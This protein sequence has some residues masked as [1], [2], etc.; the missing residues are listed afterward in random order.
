MA[1]PNRR[2]VPRYIPM[3][4]VEITWTSA[5]QAKWLKRKPSPV[6]ATV[7][8]VSVNGMLVDLPLEPKADPGDIVALS[9]GANHAVVR[10]VHTE[11]PVG[12]CGAHRDDELAQQ[13]VG[14]EITEMSPEFAA[15]LYAVV[16]G[17]RGDHG[18]LAEWWQRRSVA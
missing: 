6:T 5:G 17:L 12:Q 14:V 11:Q 7:L 2:L 10:V 15:D 9:S 18:Q 13:L 3:S 1:D 16:A 4:R 8:G